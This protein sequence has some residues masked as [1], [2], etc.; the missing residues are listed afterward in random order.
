MI[1]IIYGA[2]P[3]EVFMSHENKQVAVDLA[4]ALFQPSVKR[5]GPFCPLCGGDTF[6]F[7]KNNEVKGR[8]TGYK[9]LED[10]RALIEKFIAQD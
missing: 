6:R 2:L 3:G 8:E 4:S 5:K 9:S 7:I 1:R 10:F